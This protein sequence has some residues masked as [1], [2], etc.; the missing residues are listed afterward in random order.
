MPET[1]VRGDRAVAAVRFDVDL[2]EQPTLP[3]EV[4]HRLRAEAQSAGYATGWAQGRREAEVAARAAREQTAAQ[5]RE[6]AEMQALR[7]EQALSA[8]SRAVA[9]LE[10]QMVPVATELEDLIVR[11]AFALAEAV[12]GR[13]L[14]VAADPGRDAVARALA[15]APAGR[16]V[17]VR[18]H[19]ADHATVTGG[20][21]RSVEM[22]G[23]TVTL[24]ADP[25]LQ[26][27]DAVAE[28]DVTTVDARIA[29]ALARAREVL[30]L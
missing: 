9:H 1:V 11:T 23:R 16:P 22:D 4:A 24:L 2:R 17:T 14:A 13:E 15:L 10:R 26:P 12:I 29:P 20:Q 18:L 5:V 27:G 7:V 3:N 19:P 6:Q 30:G 21:L 8:V 28:C 25:G